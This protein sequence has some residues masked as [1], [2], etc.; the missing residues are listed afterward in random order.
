MVHDRDG[1]NRGKYPSVSG[2][3]LVR[4]AYN[5]KNFGSRLYCFNFDNFKIK[6]KL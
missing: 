5:L 2:R 6:Y 4:D 1:S 3:I